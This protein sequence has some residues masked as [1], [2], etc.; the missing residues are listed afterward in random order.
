[1]VNIVPKFQV[2]SSNCFGVMMLEDGEEKDELINQLINDK[3][4]C[5]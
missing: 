4:V 3:G 5:I 2:P 1:M